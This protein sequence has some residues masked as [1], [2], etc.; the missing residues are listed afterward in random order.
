MSQF[1]FLDTGSTPPTPSDIAVNGDVGTAVS[2]SDVLNLFTSDTNINN[3]N[4]I[5]S[6]CSGNTI[7]VKLTNRLTGYVST[8]DATPS[9]LIT[10]NLGS[11]PGTY[12]AEGN[13]VAYNVTDAAG[14]A[15]T[16]IG[17]ATTDGV[18]AT[19]IQSDNKIIFE[20]LA[21]T[22]CDFNFGVTGNT[23]FIEVIGIPAKVINWSGLF[24]YRFVGA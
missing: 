8:N 22:S 16:F 10:V 5:I 1:S 3:D 13:V 17:A 23:A 6:E 4:G 12:I 24:T 2:V 15:Y 21:M 18:T 14:G 7:N 20:Q 19:E 11:A 9:T